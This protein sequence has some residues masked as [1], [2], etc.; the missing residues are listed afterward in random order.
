MTHRAVIGL[1]G[2]EE[3]GKSTAAAH[4]EQKHGFT[5]VKFAGPLKDMTRAFGF[6]ED[7]IEGHLKNIPN[8]KLTHQNF[9]SLVEKIEA[10]LL[11]IG[12]KE[13]AD[14]GDPSPIPILGRSYAFCVFSLAGILTQVIARGEKAGG[15]SPRLLMQLLGTEFGR[16]QISPTLWIDLWKARVE[17]LPAGAM[18]VADDCRFPNEV[19]SIHALTPFSVVARIV[20]PNKDASSHVSELQT[21][22]VDVVIDNDAA[23]EG[24]L[25]KVD[26]LVL[27]QIAE[28]TAMIQ[29]CDSERAFAE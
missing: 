20:R 11:V 2:R 6:N 9:T 10:A 29:P 13:P 27:P 25:K 21:F 23:V 7:E 8:E 22:K 26:A 19:E 14:M 28:D 16:D 17:S 5:T 4:L 3:S 1:A 15:G 12:A 24:L 18:V